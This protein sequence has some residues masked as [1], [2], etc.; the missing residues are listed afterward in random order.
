MI[1]ESAARSNLHSLTILKRPVTA[2]DHLGAIREPRSYRV[3]RP[4][5]AGDHHWLTYD[6]LVD[7]NVH[8]QDRALALDG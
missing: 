7:N 1:R 6:H 8:D 3:D 2:D 5:S 4:F